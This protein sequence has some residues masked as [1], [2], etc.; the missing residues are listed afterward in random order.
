MKNPDAEPIPAPP[1]ATEAADWR[2]DLAI[3]D[4]DPRTAG[5]ANRPAWLVERV[6][7]DGARARRDTVREPSP[8]IADLTAE[9]WARLRGE[10]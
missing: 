8:T 5:R 4:A 3:L 7:A 9:A 2:R 10:S 6:L 1:D